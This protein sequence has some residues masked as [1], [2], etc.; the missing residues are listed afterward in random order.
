MKRRGI[1]WAIA[2]LVAFWFVFGIVWAVLYYG[3]ML[4]VESQIT[5]LYGSSIF[6]PTTASFM[7][8][9]GAFWP[10]IVTGVLMLWLWQESNKRDLYY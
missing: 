4:P 5:T 3:G 10:M 1:G 7:D 6:D 2:A 8:A 9:I